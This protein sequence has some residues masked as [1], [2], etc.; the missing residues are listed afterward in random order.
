VLEVG[1]E[2]FQYCNFVVLL[3]LTLAIGLRY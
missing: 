1:K 3:V 2:I